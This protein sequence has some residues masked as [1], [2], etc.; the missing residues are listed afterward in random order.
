M[1]PC[2]RGEL[3]PASH[4]FVATQGR[5]KH[6]RRKPSSPHK[7]DPGGHCEIDAGQLQ[8]GVRGGPGAHGTSIRKHSAP[9]HPPTFP[10][11]RLVLQ[12]CSQ[13]QPWLQWVC[14]CFRR[15]GDRGPR[16]RITCTIER[17][18]KL[19]AARELIDTASGIF[20]RSKG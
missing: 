2:R 17:P 12:L 10:R 16:K 1:H 4:T 11:F 13:P 14:T 9:E 20:G 3:G 6:L 19:V 18:L 8:Q 15:M 7:P 5:R